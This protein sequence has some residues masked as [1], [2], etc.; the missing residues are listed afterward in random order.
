[1]CYV[2]PSGYTMNT[3]GELIYSGP[4]Q[5]CPVCLGRGWMPAGFYTVDPNLTHFSC[6]TTATETCRTCG[7]KGTIK[8]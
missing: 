1:M 5:R 4:I 3:A 6:S 8:L 7:G 2:M